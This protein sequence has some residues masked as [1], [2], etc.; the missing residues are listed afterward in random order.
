LREE[1]TARQI[2]AQLWSTGCVGFC[3]MEVIVDIKLPKS[4][5]VSYARVTPADVPAILDAAF[6]Q[7]RS[8]LIV[9]WVSIRPAM[10][11][12][13]MVSQPLTM[14][15][16]S[17]N[18][19]NCSCQLRSDQSGEHRSV[20]GARRLSRLG[21]DF[22]HHAPVDVIEEI[23]KSGLRGRGGGGFPTGKKWEFAYKEKANKNI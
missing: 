6:I 17:K 15:R 16:F 12:L 11:S 23:K 5:R 10:A 9:F 14:C 8:I 7:A 13:S 21:Q 3:S 4:A 20:F 18:R 1:L 19:K 22:E 2:D